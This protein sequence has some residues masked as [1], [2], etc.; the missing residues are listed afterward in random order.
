MDIL[1]TCKN[2]DLTPSLR[3]Y[4]EEKLAKLSNF[5][6][7]IIRIR[8]ELEVDKNR[9]GGLMHKATFTLEVPGPDIRVSEESGDMRAAIDIA[10]PILERQVQK[11]KQKIE[12]SDWRQMRKAKEKFWNWYNRMRG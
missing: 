7:R 5:W 6:E 3:T 2:F 1:I 4:T 10:L 9:R 8:V 12:K 11:A